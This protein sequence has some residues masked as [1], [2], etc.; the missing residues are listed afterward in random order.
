MD[1]NNL[2]NHWGEKSLVISVL[3]STL[4]SPMTHQVPFS[5][6]VC[7]LPRQVGCLEQGGVLEMPVFPQG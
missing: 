1:P 3:V 6:F 7:P 5:L 4:G 2:F